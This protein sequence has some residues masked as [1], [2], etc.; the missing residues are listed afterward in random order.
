MDENVVLAFVLL[1][2]D[3]GVTRIE[4]RDVKVGEAQDAAVAAAAPDDYVLAVTAHSIVR[5]HP[6]PQIELGTGESTDV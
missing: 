6:E 1:G 2:A 4:V 3:G 5:V